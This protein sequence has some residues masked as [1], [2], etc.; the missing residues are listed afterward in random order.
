MLNQRRLSDNVGE[1]M[2]SNGLVLGF[3]RH[4][5]WEY[6]IWHIVL[7]SFGSEHTTSPFGS[8]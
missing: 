5:A 3:L 6:G 8:S 4:L 7:G 2:I 1:L